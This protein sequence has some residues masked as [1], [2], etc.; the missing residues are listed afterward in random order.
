MQYRIWS[1]GVLECWSTG[2][3]ECATPLLQYSNIPFLLLQYIRQLFL[4]FQTFCAFALEVIINRNLR[5][6]DLD[7][8]FAQV[9]RHHASLYQVRAARFVFLQDTL[10]FFGSHKGH[11]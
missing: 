10:W 7:A 2:I 6:L 11:Q 9:L 8:I 1:I 3:L 5:L 4:E